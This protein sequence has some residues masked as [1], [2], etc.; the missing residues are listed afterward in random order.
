MRSEPQ[1][2]LRDAREGTRDRRSAVDGEAAS[3]HGAWNPMADGMR[4]RLGALRAE[5]SAL[6]LVELAQR[7]LALDGR[8]AAPIAR[9]LV[10]A[11]LGARPESLPDE[12]SASALRPA[13]ESA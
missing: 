3:E 9:R 7:L 1:A 4:R 13:E 12:I 8:P 2:Y 10:A 6:P 5:G 11:L